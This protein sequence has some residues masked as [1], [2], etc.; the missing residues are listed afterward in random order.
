MSWTLTRLIF[1]LYLEVFLGLLAGVLVVFLV[2]DFSDRLGA[3]IDRPISDVALLY[4]NKLL[5][6][7]HQ[8]TPAAMLLA[9]G[10]TVSTLRKR[11]EWIAMQSL[12]LSRMVI[13]LPVALV[14]LTSAAG[15]V[16]YDELVV[17][18][19]GPAID[20]MLVERFGRYGDFSLFY[21][22]HRWFRVEHHLVYVRGEAGPGWLKDVSFY[23]LDDAFRL[24]RRFDA[25]EVK[26]LAGDR[27]ALTQ[28]VER[29]F[30]SAD[31]STVEHHEQLV[32]RLPGSS[33][34]TFSVAL[35]RPEYMRTGELLQQLAVRERVGFATERLRFALHNRFTYPAIGVAGTML[36]LALALRRT[37]KG[38]ITQALLEG[39]VVTLGLFA[40]VLAAKS[41]VLG[42]RLSAGLAAWGPVLVLLAVSLGM[43][44][45]AE[46]PR[47]AA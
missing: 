25:A 21:S 44:W 30:P 13:V 5:V 17:T 37:R 9:G 4:W 18:R 23:E 12:G 40:M 29:A 7:I 11:G 24:V 2:G 47:R 32:L 3:Y 31:V 8:L 39:L 10:V 33:A 34:D 20:R 36:T 38:H 15:L 42:G 46:R 26:Y 45:N 6:A 43:G 41:L 14:A 28:A 35:G 19:A 1:R 16:A 22:P 27:W